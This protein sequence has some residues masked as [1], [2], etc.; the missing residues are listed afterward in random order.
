MFNGGSFF[1]C[2]MIKTSGN[3]KLL[4]LMVDDNM[5]FIQ[6]ML[7][8]LD[9]VRNISYINIASDYD[10][11]SRLVNQDKPDLVLLDIN[12]P[13]K[14]GIEILKKIRS[15]DKECKVIM[16]TNHADEYYRQQ[17]SEFGADLFLDKSNDFA[18]VPEIIGQ[19]ASG[20]YNWKTQVNPVL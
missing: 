18:R 10:E 3:K 15:Q 8:L 1:L 5:C 13:G 19:L 16:L 7:G 9:E 6:R 4:V 20:K 14:S 17:C 12:L 2:N 11:A